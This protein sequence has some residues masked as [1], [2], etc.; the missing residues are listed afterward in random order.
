MNDFTKK[1]LGMLLGGISQYMEEIAFME[2]K[3]DPYDCLYCKL[4]TMIDNYCEH[5]WQEDLHH[6]DIVLCIK[7]GRRE[8]WENI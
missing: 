3:G 8:W 2:K 4:K 7:C 5:K 1:E 6:L